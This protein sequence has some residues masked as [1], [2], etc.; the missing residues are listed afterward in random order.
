MYVHT[1]V[2]SSVPAN[3]TNTTHQLYTQNLPDLSSPKPK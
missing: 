3:N 2:D 1:Q